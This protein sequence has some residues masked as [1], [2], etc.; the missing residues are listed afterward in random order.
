MPNCGNKWILCSPR[1]NRLVGFFS[2]PLLSRRRKHSWESPATD[3]NY[4]A[5]QSNLGVCN[6]RGDG[7]AKYEVD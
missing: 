2:Q 5:A 1:P 7:V 3:Q 6:E 4:L